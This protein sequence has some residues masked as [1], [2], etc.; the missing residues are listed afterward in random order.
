L[1][2]GLG[3]GSPVNR[4]RIIIINEATAAGTLLP[5]PG[6]GPTAGLNGLAFDGLGALYGSAI[7]NPVFADPAPGAPTLVQLDPATGAS[8]FSVPIIFGGNPLEVL[9]L[10]AQPGTG[11]IYG[12]SFTSTVPGTSIYTINKT[13]GVATLV[14]ATGVIGVT[15][16]FAP[17]ATLYMSSAT[18]SD[19]GDQTGSFLHTV[20][21]LTGSI[22]STVAIAPLPSGNFVHIGG[23]GVRPTDGVLFA[24]GREATAFQ[25]G[26]IYTLSTTGTA[27]LVGSTGV[28][29]VGD[30]A[31]TPIPE[32]TTLLL[33]S[34]GLLGVGAATR[35]RRRT[36][37]SFGRIL[38]IAEGKTS[39]PLSESSKTATVEC[40]VVPVCA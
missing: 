32:P 11:L 18:F 26:A 17:D 5:A 21:P 35:K 30:L 29:E 4:G 23:L 34:T 3:F 16:A 6:V 33:L 20:S 27:T 1:F 22:L 40:D 15:L 2:G 38:K 13:T 19:V 10:A 9:D 8:I 7:S 31:F 37:E 36:N 24:A 25:K 28:G 12:T 39:D 14:G